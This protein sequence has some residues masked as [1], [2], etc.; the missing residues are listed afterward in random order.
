MQFGRLSGRSPLYAHLYTLMEHSLAQPDKPD[1]NFR[2]RLHIAWMCLSVLVL[3]ADIPQWER[4]HHHSLLMD[5]P[6]KEKRGVGTENETLDK[7]CR[8]G[9]L[10]P[11]S[12]QGWLQVESHSYI[13]G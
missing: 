13:T 2:H 8:G 3:Q 12:Q 4:H 10:E 11:Q 5:M 6:A 9:G 7:V 1:F